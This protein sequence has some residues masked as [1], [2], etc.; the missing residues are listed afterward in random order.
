MMIFVPILDS[1]PPASSMARIS[2]NCCLT[3]HF[4][5]HDIHADQIVSFS[6][7]PVSTECCDGFSSIHRNVA[8]AKL[9][10]E[11]L[12]QNPAGE[13]IFDNKGPHLK[14][15]LFATPDWLRIWNFSISPA[16]VGCAR[17]V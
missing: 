3:I 16:D 4:R 14:F 15:L 6:F 10:E 1:L 5:H 8:F 2:L 11:C 9:R 12:Q 17:P 13:V 7:R